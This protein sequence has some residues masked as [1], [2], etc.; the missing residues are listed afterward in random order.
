[1][2]GDKFGVEAGVAM[3]GMT[4]VALLTFAIGVFVGVVLGQ[5]DS[6]RIVLIALML[7]LIMLAAFI[8]LNLPFMYRAYKLALQER[9]ERKA[10]L[11]PDGKVS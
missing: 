1:M 5:V 10:M 9:Q 11:E 3:I 8:I 6:I 7:A 4:A 2:V